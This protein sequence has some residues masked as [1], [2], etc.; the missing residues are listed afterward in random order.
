MRGSTIGSDKRNTSGGEVLERV[1]GKCPVVELKI[2]RVTVS[3]LLD[4]GRQVSTVS[5]GF[6]RENC[7]EDEDMLS[8]S[9]WLKITAANGLD[10]SK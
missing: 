5:E 1:V 2:E 4:M 9:V 7:G 10:I 6:F 3:C 8:M